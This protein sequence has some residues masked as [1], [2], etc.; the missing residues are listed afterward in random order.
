MNERLD[1]NLT[2]AI[3]DQ[4]DLIVILERRLSGSGRS[5]A[6]VPSHKSSEAETTLCQPL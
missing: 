3:V 6:A 1:F 5:S 4:L 2:I